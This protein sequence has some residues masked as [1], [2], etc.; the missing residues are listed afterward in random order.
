M[1]GSILIIT[2]FSAQDGWEEDLTDEH[3]KFTTI[4]GTKQKRK[5]MLTNLN[6]QYCIA[7]K[8][9]YMSAPEIK[10]IHWD[11]IIVDEADF[12]SNNSKVSKFYLKNFKHTKYKI[13]LSGTPMNTGELDLVNLLL[14]VDRKSLPIKDFWHFRALYCMQA[15]YNWIIKPEFARRFKNTVASYFYF[16]RRKDWNLGREKVYKKHMV[17]LPPVLRKA[18]NNLEKNYILEYKDIKLSTSYAIDA[19]TT[20]MQMLGG[21]INE[22]FEY[23]GKLK[24]LKEILSKL[25]KHEPVV[26]YCRHTVEILMLEKELS[27]LYATRIHYGQMK[28]KIKLK[29]R[30]DFMKGKF[31]KFIVQ[32]KSFEY[33][34]DAS[35]STTVIF[36]SQPNGAKTKNQSEDRVITLKNKDMCLIIDILCKDTIDEDTYI[37]TKLGRFKRDI[38]EKVI[39]RIKERQSIY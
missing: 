37:A 27:N 38:F 33:G 20:M 14:F 30:R 3:Q 15:G 7:N 28:N 32:P 19:Y 8:E 10:D 34:V 21:F 23:D 1:N 18:Y 16:A 11:M 29:N 25:H 4:K 5:D 35:I 31:S 26:I 36:Y 13:I 39:K 6:T 17:E 22:E 24:A 2:P 12:L 9:M